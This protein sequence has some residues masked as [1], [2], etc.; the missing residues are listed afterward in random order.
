[1]TYIGRIISSTAKKAGI[2]R[3]VFP[4]LIRHTRLT[5]LHRLGVRGL[6]HN[7]FAGHRAGSKQQG[8]YVHL[9]NDDMK[10]AVLEKVYN[11]EDTPADQ[12]SKYE[13]EIGALKQELADVVNYLGRL[14]KAMG[15]AGHGA[16]DQ[17]PAFLTTKSVEN[18]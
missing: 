9:D 4:Y 11:I 10:H 2:E 13:R 17:R 7:K 1:M 6:E 8:V 14:S 16:E 15:F 18:S 5:E 12:V 3:R